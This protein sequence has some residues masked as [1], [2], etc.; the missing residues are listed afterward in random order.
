[1]PNAKAD[2]TAPPQSPCKALEMA[3]MNSVSI[4]MPS[5]LDI[6]PNASLKVCFMPS[7]M[8]ADTFVITVWNALLTSPQWSWIEFAKISMARLPVSSMFSASARLDANP[9]NE[10]FEERISDC[11]LS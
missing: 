8:P 4:W 6:Q 3:E 5:S 11:L 1:M 9:M 2:A 10:L 7:D